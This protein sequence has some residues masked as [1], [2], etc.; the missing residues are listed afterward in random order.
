MK[1]LKI[2][3]SPFRNAEWQGHKTQGGNKKT[4][5]IRVSS[6]AHAG[7]RDKMRTVEE[8]RKQRDMLQYE[9]NAGR[10]EGGMGHELVD[11]RRT[12][13]SSKIFPKIERSVDSMFDRARL[14][15]GARYSNVFTS[16]PLRGAFDG[17]PEEGASRPG[18]EICHRGDQACQRATGALVTSYM[19][20]Y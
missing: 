9:H 1:K 16:K 7:R 8:E 3:L 2:L 5:E 4:R 12:K 18:D 6:G 13:P 10:D 17:Q 14:V 19:P 11:R 15:V 20:L